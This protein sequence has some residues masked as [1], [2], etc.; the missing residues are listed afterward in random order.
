MSIS[1]STRRAGPYAGNGATVAFGFPF[2]VFA[3]SDLRVAKT[4]VGGTETD[5]VLGT[6]YAVSLNSAQDTNPGGTVTA[7]VAPLTGEKLTILSAVA[8]VQPVVLQNAG[9][10]YPAVLNDALD[11]NTILVQQLGELLG[12][13][14]ALPISYTG[15]TALP[16]PIPS[17]VLGWNAT[18]SGLDNIDTATLATAIAYGGVSADTFTGN[19]ATTVFVLSSSPGSINNL[20]VSVA[21]VVQVPTTNYTWDGTTGITF[22]VAPANGAK[23]YIRFNQGL[24]Q[25]S[26][27]DGAVST[28]GKVVDGILSP[29][30]LTAGAPSW[31]SS[32]N[33][34]AA[35]TVQAGGGEVKI[36]GAA[37]SLRT[38]S[39]RT[40]GTARWAVGGDTTAEGGA[41]AGTDWVL[42]RYSDAGSLLG[43]ALTINRATGAVSTEAGLTVGGNLTLAA[44][45]AFSAATGPTSTLAVGFRGAPQNAQN[46]NYTLVL[47]DAGRSVYSVNSGAQTITIPTNASVAFPV[48]TVVVLFNN[49]TTAITIST[50]GVTLYY[51]GTANVGNRTVSTKG[52]VSLLK[53]AADTWVISGSGIA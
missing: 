5:L 26:I 29:A 31:D 40:A 2:K 45:A 13:T 48:G 47:S 33:L 37:G 15:S 32:G 34:S 25:G 11:R 20:D 3:T 8:S 22:L 46:S 9:G 51:A 21:G 7:V 1:S 28:A 50:T 6:D 16:G 24:A 49:G 41:N 36:T 30:K 17:G 43:T 44:D 53:V 35:G 12:R 23:V 14:V 52:L 42:R 27:S 38:L 19:G 18:G 39:I 4:S 10:F